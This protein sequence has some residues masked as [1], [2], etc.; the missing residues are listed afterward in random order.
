MRPVTRKPKRVRS[1]SAEIGDIGQ[2]RG[3]HRSAG[4]GSRAA[5]TQRL[6]RAARTPRESLIHRASHAGRAG[7]KRVAVA[8]KGARERS[9]A[10]DHEQAPAMISPAPIAA[11]VAAVVS[12]GRGCRSES[13]RARRER[14]ERGPGQSRG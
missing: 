11:A 12:Q 13:Q 3:S 5:R 1:T 7:P 9:N 2:R 8:S 14:A 4:P 10:T 6:D